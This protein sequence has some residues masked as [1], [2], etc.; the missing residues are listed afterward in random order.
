MFLKKLALLLYFM[1]TPSTL[2][3]LLFIWAFFFA[4]ASNF[5]IPPY[6]IFL[7]SFFLS[8]SFFLCL[9]ILLFFSLLAWLSTYFYDSNWCL[10]SFWI[11]FCPFHKVRGTFSSTTIASDCPFL[12][13]SLIGLGTKLK[14]ESESKK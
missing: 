14:F 9:A 10:P 12:V 5:V 7:L 2:R 1:F 3:G 11:Y 6:S 8:C 13:L 4:W